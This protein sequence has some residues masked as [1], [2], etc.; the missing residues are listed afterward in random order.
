MN[1]QSRLLLYKYWINKT[2]LSN[3]TLLYFEVSQS[4]NVYTHS[5]KKNIYWFFFKK[6]IWNTHIQNILQIRIIKQHL[7][8]SK[9]IFYEK[10]SHSFVLVFTSLIGFHIYYTSYVRLSW[11]CACKTFYS[12]D[13][14]SLRLPNVVEN[15]L[16]DS[17]LLEKCGHKCRI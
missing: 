1:I 9:W 5:K 12:V 2:H 6:Y 11:T 8:N 15:G 3:N 16:I 7:N 17:S 13:M 14:W 4:K 10:K